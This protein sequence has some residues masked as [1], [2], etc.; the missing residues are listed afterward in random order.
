MGQISMP[1]R[2][3]AADSNK[4]TMPSKRGKGTVTVLQE[5][6]LQL[7]LGAAKSL[8]LKSCGI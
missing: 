3:V 5:S 6:R 2:L 8:S 1:G 4:H 7:F